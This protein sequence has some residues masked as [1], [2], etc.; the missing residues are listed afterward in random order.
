MRILFFTQA[1]DA[2]G[3][4]EMEMSVPEILDAGALWRKLID[5]YPKL[6]EFRETTRLARNSE[7]ADAKTFFCDQ[8]EVALIPP[9]SGG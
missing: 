4:A 2:T 1:R 6:A 7:Y 8:D 3:T 9:V 5:T